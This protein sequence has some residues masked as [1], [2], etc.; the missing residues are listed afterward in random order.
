MAFELLEHPYDSRAEERG[1]RRRC[2]RSGAAMARILYLHGSGHTA[3]SFASQTLAFAGSQALAL[4]GHPTG[5]PLDTVAELA[6]WL[7]GEIAAPAGEPAVIC[8][9]S[10][11]A[12]VALETAL[13]HPAQVAGLILIGGG[14]RLRV[15]GQF[16]EMIDEDWPGCIDALVDLSVDAG[17]PD[18]LRRRL[19]D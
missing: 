3:E 10:L 11:G 8:G 14:A 9:N 4:P 5:A 19:A 12:A 15:G 6:H 18:D 2:A 7:A 1:S 17:C 13:S 16:F